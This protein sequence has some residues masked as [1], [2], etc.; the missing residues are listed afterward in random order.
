MLEPQ[1]EKAIAKSLDLAAIVD[2]QMDRLSSLEQSILA[3]AFQTVSV[4]E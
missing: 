1:L 2:R 3:A 4:G